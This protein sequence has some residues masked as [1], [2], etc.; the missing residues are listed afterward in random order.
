[1]EAH[2]FVRNTWY[3][4]GLSEEFGS[5]RLQGQT[6][7]GKPLVM[8]RSTSG[9]VV[10]FDGRCLHKRMPLNNGKLLPDD[11]LECAYH[12]FCYDAS[13][14]CVRVPAHPDGRIPPSWKLKPY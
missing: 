8:W 9:Q 6:V 1:M 13:G 11:T 5:G 2:T 4:V 7:A 14:T 12:G 10:A 3:V